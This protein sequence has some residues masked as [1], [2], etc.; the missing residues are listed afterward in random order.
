MHVNTMIT[1]YVNAKNNADNL[2]NVLKDLREKILNE[3]KV[4]GI[5]EYVTENSKAVYSIRETVTYDDEA[6]KI[7]KTVLPESVTEKANNKEIKD[8]IKNGKLDELK[9]I[10]DINKRYNIQNEHET[11]FMAFVRDEAD[12]GNNTS[13]II[14]DPGNDYDIVNIRNKE[15]LS[16]LNRKDLNKKI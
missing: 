15:L 8:S 5:K 3:M 11:I 14:V 7:L 4:R 1:E 10:E 16:K 12:I 6:V 2:N 13:S 9:I